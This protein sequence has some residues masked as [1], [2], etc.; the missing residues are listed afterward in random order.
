MAERLMQPPTPQGDIV[1][2]RVAAR[3]F[4]HAVRQYVLARPQEEWHIRPRSIPACVRLC[5]GLCQNLYATLL[6]WTA[7]ASER[8]RGKQQ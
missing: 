4:N 3:N 8:I 1:H 5:G 7:D 6:L 2:D